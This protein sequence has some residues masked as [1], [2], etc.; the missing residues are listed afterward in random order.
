MAEERVYRLEPASRVWK[1]EN[2]KGIDYS[3]GDDVELKILEILRNCSDVSVNSLELAG[4]ISDW[5]T[6]YHFSHLRSNLLRP[7]NL[8]PSCRVLELGCGC[9]AITRYLGETGADVVAVDGSLRRSSI[10]AERCRDLPNVRVYCDN[11]AAFA[12]SN[13]FD[14]VTLIGVLEYAPLYISGEN[15][16]RRC[17]SAA[18]D[19][20]SDVGTLLVAIENQLGLKYLTGCS[21]DHLGLPYFGIQDLYDSRTPRTFG[22]LELENLVRSVASP[23]NLLFAYPFPD[24]K[25]PDMVISE[26]GLR[27]TALD[28]GSLLCRIISRDPLRG[29]RSFRENLARFPIVRNDLLGQL[30][31]SFLVLAACGKPRVWVA[32]EWLASA[33][34][35]RRRDALATETQFIRRGAELI[36]TKA[37]L[38]GQQPAPSSPDAQFRCDLPPTSNYVEGRLLLADLQRHAARARWL[39]DFSDALAPW[40]RLLRE[41]TDS[42]ALV[43]ATVPNSFVDCIPANVVITN[44]GSAVF[45]DREWVAR[46]RIPLLWVL[47][48]GI[49]NAVAHCSAPENERKIALRELIT[50]ILEPH[51]IILDDAAYSAAARWEDEFS[52]AAR[53][54]RPPGGFAARLDSDLWTLD[55]V[56]YDSNAIAQLTMDVRQ[57]SRDLET[58]RKSW[59]WRCTAPLR[60]TEKAIR[61][62]LTSR[63]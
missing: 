40:I 22:H 42:E 45:I 51:R 48:R 41:N 15:P 4:H 18:V 60:L 54:D 34:A 33:Y 13:R 19:H 5:P 44:D 8:G 2:H 36:V 61:K 55:G 23:R 3:D 37:C 59:V 46:T 24:Y 10:A 50:K 53:G 63:R 58:I 21:E 49:A 20:L 31:N 26:D 28:V 43:S 14:L 11:L 27:D 17:L 57:L 9:G 16:A 25:L 62:W 52:L 56:W 38:S 29:T 7:L 47:V 6:E 1:T 35:T 30:A 12:A 39:P 32:P